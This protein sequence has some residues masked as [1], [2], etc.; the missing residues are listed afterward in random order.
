MI[1]AAIAAVFVI[2]LGIQIYQIFQL[3]DRITQMRVQENQASI[4]KLKYQSY[5][6]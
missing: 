2:V 5:P 6:I 1:N 4:L 3:N